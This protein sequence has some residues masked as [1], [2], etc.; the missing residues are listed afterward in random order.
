MNKNLLIG[1]VILLVGGLWYFSSRQPAY[2]PTDTADTVTE[3][4]AMMAENQISLTLAE[5][6]DSGESG[7]ATLVET[8]GTVTVTLALTGFSVGVSQPAHIHVGS[9]PEVGAVSYPLTNVVDGASATPLEVTLAQLEA[10]M[11]LAINVHKSATEASV[12]TACGDL[13]F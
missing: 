6:N 3:D 1:L 7:T 10:E 9:C 8:D 11:P 12:Y 13:E 2:A 5:L 4:E